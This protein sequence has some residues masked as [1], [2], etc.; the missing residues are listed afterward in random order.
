MDITINKGETIC[1]I[2]ENGSGKSTLLKIFSGITY[3]TTGSIEVNGRVASVLEIGT[4]F[5]PELSGKDNIYL[6]G[7]LLG[8]RKK[9]IDSVYNAI[10]EFSEI[11]QFI[12]MP[13]KHYSSGMN[14]R[15]AFSIVIHLN[16][17]IILFDETLSVG[18]QAFKYKAINKIKKLNSAGKTVIIVTHYLPDALAFCKRTLLL[19]KGK[20][21]SFDFSYIVV[22][23]Y[24]NYIKDKSFNDFYKESDSI[25]YNDSSFF[26][27][28]NL[29]AKSSGLIIDNIVIKCNDKSTNDP[30]YLHDKITFDFYYSKM[31]NHLKVNII[32]MIVDSFY[33]TIFM[34]TN[35]FGDNN[36]KKGQYKTSFTL[37]SYFLNEGLYSLYVIIFD[38]LVPVIHIPSGLL[39][40]K[41]LYSNEDINHINFP[42]YPCPLYPEFNWKEEL[43]CEY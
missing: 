35:M 23:Q 21:I 1:I 16:A 28:L 19:E 27:S 5:H 18:D 33:N 24:I 11:G 43:I 37:P 41:I 32:V 6:N 29:N 31:Q 42:K 25:V 3:P 7:L 38:G 2:G 14:A 20:L 4:G 34:A 36:Q 13:V 8:M 12:N 15:L 26:K 10:I 40:F 30:I 17:D 39:T 22:Q 9:E